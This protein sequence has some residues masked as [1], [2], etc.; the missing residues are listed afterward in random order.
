VSDAEEPRARACAALARAGITHDE[1][2]V[3]FLAAML[4]MLD[5]AAARVSEGLAPEQGLAPDAS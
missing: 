3:A 4:P 2:D 5:D 1:D